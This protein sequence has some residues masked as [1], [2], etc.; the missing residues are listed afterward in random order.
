[1]V[2]RPRKTG[3]LRTLAEKPVRIAVASAEA[4]AIAGGAATVG[5]LS[6]DK[7]VAIAEEMIQG[8]G[9]PKEEIAAM[10]A[11]LQELKKIKKERGIERNWESMGT[12][13]GLIERG[14]HF[15]ERLYGEY[16]GDFGAW[17]MESEP[18]LEERIGI[19]EGTNKVL[20]VTSY[21]ASWPLYLAMFLTVSA[22]T[23]VTING[24][25]K[26]L[27]RRLDE[28]EEGEDRET[29]T[30][31]V[32][33][34]EKKN[35]ELMADTAVARAFFNMGVKDKKV[36]TPQ[37]VEQMT[38]AMVRGFETI[39]SLPPEA[40]EKLPPRIRGIFQTGPDPDEKKD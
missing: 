9:F 25:L 20:D 39:A 32:S 22:G 18:V 37:H 26:Y 29:L 27:R 7:S 12:L 24:Y 11:K 8:L 5:K 6:A 15:L 13:P 3:I 36:L 19:R 21:L 10:K 23:A 34:L 17:A 28:M 31:R 30:R 14:R 38:E 1:M 2:E 40:L 4:A 35:T 33:D 16:G